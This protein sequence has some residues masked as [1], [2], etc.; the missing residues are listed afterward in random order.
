MGKVFSTVALF[1]RNGQMTFRQ[2]VKQVQDNITQARKA[3]A[4]FW[5]GA[6]KEPDKIIRVV[7]IHG[8]AQ[9]IYL[10]ERTATGRWV[11][12]VIPAN[13]AAEQTHLAACMKELGIDHASAPPALPEVIEINGVIYRREI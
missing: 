6:I 9:R 13:V 8:D 4:R 2:P 7:V 3:A 1:R 10:S 12:T 11:E 5:G